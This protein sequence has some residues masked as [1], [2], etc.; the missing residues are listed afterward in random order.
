MGQAAA[1]LMEQGFTFEEVRLGF[2][3]SHLELTIAL[4][5]HL[6]IWIELNWLKA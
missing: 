5:C 3:V 2:Q 4:E 1:G 6:A